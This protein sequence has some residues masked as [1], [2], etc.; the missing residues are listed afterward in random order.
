MDI[1]KINGFLGKIQ[2]QGGRDRFSPTGPA[3][4]EGFDN[5]ITSGMEKVNKELVESEKMS[6]EFLVEG[7]HDLH[8]VMISME[9]ADL[10]FRYM[11]QVRNKILDAY[12]EVMR[13]Q[14]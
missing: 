3:G 8:E 13:M 1:S 9:K 5:F 2:E 10:S 7:K 11:T 14:V 4:A 6:Q 12:S